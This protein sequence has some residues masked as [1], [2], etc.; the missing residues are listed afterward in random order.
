[1][2]ETASFLGTPDLELGAANVYVKSPISLDWDDESGW[3]DLGLVENILWRRIASKTDLLAAQGGTRPSD[4]V[5]TEQRVQIE[6]GL[7]Q[8]FLERLVLVVQD[9]KLEKTGDVVNQWMIVNKLGERDSQARFWLRVIKINAG[10]ESADPLDR[11]YSLVSPMSET[12]ELTYDA[13]T[14]RFFG[15]LFEAYL[16]DDSASNFPVSHSDGEFAFAWSRVVP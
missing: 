5:I 11:A 16:N 15:L 1:M 7:G 12:V 2:A 9:L 8:A 3:V 13:A 6:A 4:K 14:Q 10:I